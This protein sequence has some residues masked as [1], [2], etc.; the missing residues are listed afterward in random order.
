M[1]GAWTKLA[2]V[3]GSIRAS[4][5]S[6][7]TASHLANEA[8]SAD[9]VVTFVRGLL[10]GEGTD[11][12]LEGVGALSDG[13]RVGKLSLVMHSLEPHQE[14]VDHLVVLVILGEV[15]VAGRFLPLIRS[16]ALVGRLSLST[17]GLL[18]AT[19][20][21][22][23]LHLLNTLEQ[24]SLLVL[25]ELMEEEVAQLAYEIVVWHRRLLLP[26]CL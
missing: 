1:A 15:C 21:T 16:R 20:A 3:S 13:L 19:T 10:N 26:S 8:S 2:I 17:T 14:L 22:N 12:V 18:L 24:C 23:L 7:P 5:G 25:V 4:G 11:G 9:G 6:L